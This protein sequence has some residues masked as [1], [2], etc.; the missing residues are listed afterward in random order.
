MKILLIKWLI[1][2]IEVLFET[3]KPLPILYFLRLIKYHF[4]QL[5]KFR[6]KK[7]KIFLSLNISRKKEKVHNFCIGV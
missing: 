6:F 5:Q 2:L 1:F 7:F 3:A 4:W